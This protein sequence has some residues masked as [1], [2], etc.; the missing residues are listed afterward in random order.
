MIKIYKMSTKNGHLLY[1][2][3]N[4]NLLGTVSQP[5]SVKIF[6]RIF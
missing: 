1:D 2:H 3:D 6:Q 4:D 5:L